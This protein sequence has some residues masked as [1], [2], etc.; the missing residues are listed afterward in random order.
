MLAHCI[1]MMCDAIR[2]I[3][4][5]YESSDY[6]AFMTYKEIEIFLSLGKEHIDLN[7]YNNYRKKMVLYA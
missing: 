4:K 6:S 7:S 1:V 5:C 2:L 3:G